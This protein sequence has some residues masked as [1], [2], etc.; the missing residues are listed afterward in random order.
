MSLALKILREN[1]ENEQITY[2]KP[3]GGY[4]IWFEVK[5]K[6]ITEEN[7]LNL[8]NENEVIVTKGSSSFYTTTK[9]P[10]FR[11]SIAHRDQQEI[12]KGLSEIIKVLNSLKSN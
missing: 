10:C 3:I 11:I 4:T 1:L 2:A 12:E 8:F 5:N 9:Y 6:N 7:L